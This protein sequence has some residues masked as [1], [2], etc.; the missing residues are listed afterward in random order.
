MIRRNLIWKVLLTMGFCSCG[1]QRF[2]VIR[3]PKQLT[4]DCQRLG[5]YPSTV[6]GIVLREKNGR[7]VWEVDRELGTPQLHKIVVNAGANSGALI[8]VSAGKLKKIYPI[9]DFELILDRVYEIEVR[10]DGGTICAKEE[11]SFR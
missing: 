1:G 9:G 2:L 11:F 6:T 3:E 7:V 10:G 8:G 5:E 4:V